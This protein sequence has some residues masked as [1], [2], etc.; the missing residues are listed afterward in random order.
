M[1][2]T[3]ALTPSSSRRE[4][5][6]AQVEVPVH[7]IQEADHIACAHV[8]A[9]D[10]SSR[11]TRP[12]AGSSLSRSSAPRR[13]AARPDPDSVRQ[14]AVPGRLVVRDVLGQIQVV[15]EVPLVDQGSKTRPDWVVLVG[16][17]R[18]G[19]TCASRFRVNAF[20]LSNAFS[21]FATRTLRHHGLATTSREVRQDRPNV[22]GPRHVQ[23]GRHVDAAFGERGKTNSP[24]G[25]TSRGPTE[26]CRVTRDQ[27]T[28]VVMESHRV[29]AANAPAAGPTGLTAD[30]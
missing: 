24:A 30:V 9:V 6:R 19:L 1:F 23:I 14:P 18:V 21:L 8:L 4:F 12:C 13:P 16:P 26:Y 5:R 28:F 22:D 15:C 10:V 29:V 3:S 17:L 11:D 2:V 20:Q 25:P 7:L 27:F